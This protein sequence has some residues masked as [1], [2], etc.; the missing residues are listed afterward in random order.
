MREAGIA[1]LGELTHTHQAAIKIF[2]EEQSFILYE[3]IPL[4][5]EAIETDQCQFI[6]LPIQNSFGWTVSE[7]IVALGQWPVRHATIPVEIKAEFLYP[8]VHYLIANPGT[9]LNAIKRVCSHPQALTQS[10]EWLRGKLPGVA[11]EAAANTALAV[12]DIIGQADKAAIGTQLAAEKFEL[13]IL[14]EDIQFSGNVTRFILLGV[15]GRGIYLSRLR[16]SEIRKRLSVVF[17]VTD[18]PGSLMVALESLRLRNIN[19]ALIQS[20]PYPG[21]KWEA[22]F[23]V[24]AE[25]RNL[26]R[27][28]LGCIIEELA[29]KTENVWFLGNYP[30]F[31]L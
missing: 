23:Y 3:D 22:L 13:D 9:K 2:G 18:E 26:N 20:L 8:V 29:E 11:L 27:K 12:K 24:E 17:A 1:I 16:L 7:T 14:A 10:R 19:L 31:Q 15:K 21:R 6:L 4:M 30:S 25:A 28:T 5:F